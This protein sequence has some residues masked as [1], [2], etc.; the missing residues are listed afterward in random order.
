MTEDLDRRPEPT[1]GGLPYDF[2]KPTVQRVKRR[3]WNSEDPRMFTPKMY[4][5]GYGLNA[6]WLAHPFRYLQWKRPVE[7]E[8]QARS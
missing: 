8:G 5:W 1:A 6:F 2:R 4:G 3:G 7:P